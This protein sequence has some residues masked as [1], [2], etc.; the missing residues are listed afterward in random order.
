M[1]IIPGA[2]AAATDRESELAEPNRAE[3]DVFG[4]LQRR[5]KATLRLG[6]AAAAAILLFCR[7][8]WPPG[9]AV[10]ETIEL[11]GILLISVAVLGRTWCTLYIGGRKARDL[12]ETGPYS[13]TRN[14]LYLFS[15]IGIAGIG[16]QMG[17]ILLGPVLAG[18]AAAVFVPL[19]GEEQTL[20]AGRFGARYAAYR[21]RV[22]R[23]W[24]RP[25]LWRDDE[26]LKVSTRHLRQTL[27]DGLAFY[28]A[29]P[30]FAALEWL[31]E[32]AGLPVLLTLP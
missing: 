5:R 21:A 16:A 18:L 31:Q 17:S 24:P 26:T 11:A 4:P 9:G 7:S 10:H 32:K 25:S 29:I 15:L 2:A 22:P 19:I 14:P 30:A 1:T 6:V 20:L 13:V 8:A 28:L 12:V 3:G 23:L 27:R